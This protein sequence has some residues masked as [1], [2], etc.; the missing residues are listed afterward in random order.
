MLFVVNRATGTLDLHPSSKSLH[1]QALRLAQ[2][3][4]L[5]FILGTA[6][7]Y[8][9]GSHK[10]Q[11]NVLFSL[12]FRGLGTISRAGKEEAHPSGGGGFHIPIYMCIPRP[13]HPLTRSF[14]LVKHPKTQALLLAAVAVC[15]S[16]F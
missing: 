16:L 9:Y 7:M 14:T 11:C 15:F 10:Q 1:S 3:W 6:Y 13:S 12:N 8:I 2:P 4:I 5:F